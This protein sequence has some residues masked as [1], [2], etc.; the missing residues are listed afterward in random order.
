MPRNG[1]ARPWI[2]QGNRKNRKRSVAAPLPHVYNGITPMLVKAGKMEP[3][4]AEV[5]LQVAEGPSEIERL[6]DLL[7]SEIEES[8]ITAR[9]VR[10]AAAENQKGEAAVLGLIAAQFLPKLIPVL[11]EAIKGFVT[12]HS[13]R[14]VE[15]VIDLPHEKLSISCQPGS[16]VRIERAK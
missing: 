10:G 7:R 6:T 8:G 14:A 1:F 2:P 9:L 4:N 15:V 13:K 5:K 12:I 16:T 11:I 3:I